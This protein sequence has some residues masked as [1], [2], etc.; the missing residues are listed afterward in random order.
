MTELE[1]GPVRAIGMRAIGEGGDG[2]FGYL[3]EQFILR[4]SEVEQLNGEG[5]G[6]CKRIPDPSRMLIEYTA[7]F[8]ATESAKVPEGMVEVALPRL[9]CYVKPVAN[10]ASIGQC[11]MEGTDEY[12]KHYE[13]EPFE[14]AFPPFE[15]YPADFHPDGSLSL[16]FPI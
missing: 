13:K 16:Y 15:F 10:L 2:A 4:M 14:Q 12:R 5:F 11:W 9:R 3:W 1:Y 6:F 8:A 7:A